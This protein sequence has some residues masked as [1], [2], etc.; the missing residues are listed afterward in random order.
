MPPGQ[1][2]ACSAAPSPSPSHRLLTIRPPFPLAPQ[3]DYNQ[4]ARAIN[5]GLEM[6]PDELTTRW[7]DLNAHVVDHTAQAWAKSAP[8]PLASHTPTT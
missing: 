5:Q 8:Q 4:V 6:S 3:Y 1:P 7:K 2:G